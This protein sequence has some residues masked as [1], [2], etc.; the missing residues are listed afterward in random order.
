ME[1]EEL[2]QPYKKEKDPIVKDRPMLNI[3]IRFEGHSMTGAAY[4]LG[5]VTSC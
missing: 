2:L 1:S 3:R 5:K 4:P